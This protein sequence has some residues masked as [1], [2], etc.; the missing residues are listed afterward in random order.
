MLLWPTPER[1]GT[2]L[3]F[4]KNIRHRVQLVVCVQAVKSSKGS[5]RRVVSLQH[6]PLHPWV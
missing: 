6:R 4:D 1:K 2:N 3:S 5:R